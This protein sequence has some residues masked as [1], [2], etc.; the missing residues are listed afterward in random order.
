MTWVHL[1]GSTSLLIS[2]GRVNLQC[3]GG[4]VMYT[5]LHDIVYEVEPYVYG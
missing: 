2:R 4:V 1:C 3:F 5:D